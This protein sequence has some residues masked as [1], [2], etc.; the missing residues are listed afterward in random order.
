MEESK[1]LKIK[2]RVLSAVV[3]FLLLLGA[4]IAGR[5]K[6]MPS[7]YIDDKISH[8]VNRKFIEQD[9]I[10][11]VRLSKNGEQSKINFSIHY[12][13]AD[14]CLK[15]EIKY[16]VTK[17]TQDILGQYIE[18]ENAQL[19][20]LGIIIA[21][22]VTVIGIGFPLYIK[23]KT[24]KNIDD[25]V[26]KSEEKI[27]KLSKES[28]DDI[29]SKASKL[30]ELEKDFTKTKEDLDNY[31]E[32]TWGNKDQQDS[33][34]NKLEK[35]KGDLDNNYESI[36]NDNKHISDSFKT[37]ALEI[38]NLFCG[39]L[40]LFY[41]E[42]DE[43]KKEKF[44]TQIL[45]NKKNKQNN[46][47]NQARIK[48]SEMLYNKGFLIQQNN[49]YSKAISYYGDAISVRDNYGEAYYNR[50]ICYYN[51]EKYIEAIDDFSKVINDNLINS[52]DVFVN[53]GAAYY[54][55]RQYTEAINDLTLATQRKPNDSNALIILATVYKDMGMLDDSIN[56][57]YK[58]F[59]INESVVEIADQD[60]ATRKE[61]VDLQRKAKNVNDQNAKMQLYNE[62]ISKKEDTARFYIDLGMVYF[63]NKQ[64]STAHQY[65]SKASKLMPDNND[66]TR[67]EILTKQLLTND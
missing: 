27:N 29:D 7:Y 49:D 14:S 31:I 34:M 50:A 38:N 64:Y 43:E 10:L 45:T 19:T 41:F 22:L 16:L 58:A 15:N 33:L 52:D 35:I 42:N 21:A 40:N 39:L 32:Q 57:Y 59:D 4:F 30:S 53:R 28:K 37:E 2:I 47:L 46:E 44:I 3:M 17:S 36:K 18:S 5:G 1:K 9:S 26:N 48:H 66:Y 65:F 8:E 54:K 67:F 20:W 55:N 62:L 23:E 24:E 12:Y 60:E 56:N 25:L 6:G 63:D 61:F 13:E 11:A 51:I